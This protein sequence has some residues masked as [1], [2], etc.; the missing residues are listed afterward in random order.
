MSVPINKALFS[1]ITPITMT[2]SGVTRTSAGVILGSCVVNLFRT[3]DNKFIDTIVSDVSTGVYSFTGVGLGS[4]Y[5]VVV[6]KVG[7]PDISG[8]SLNTLVG[9]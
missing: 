8:T 7:S 6:Y 3:S 5:Y 1:N 2:L 9:I 4:T